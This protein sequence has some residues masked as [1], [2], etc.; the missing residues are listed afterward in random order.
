MLPWEVVGISYPTNWELRL[1]WE[2]LHF[3]FCFFVL[4]LKRDKKE[5]GQIEEMG[6]GIWRG[7][8]KHSH[9]FSAVC[10]M[11]LNPQLVQN[12]FR[13]HTGSLRKLLKNP[14]Q[15]CSAH[16]RTW[17]LWSESRAGNVLQGLRLLSL[18]LCRQMRNEQAR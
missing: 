3:V 17:C 6:L 7:Q 11:Y 4:F 5:K 16:S 10:L 14:T 8:V 9:A 18:L 15:T 2:N 13:D 1:T 12:P